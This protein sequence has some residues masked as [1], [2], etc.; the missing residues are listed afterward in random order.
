MGD[1]SFG[2]RL[3]VAGPLASREAIERVTRASGALGYSTLW[4]HDFIIWTRFLDRAHVS[5]GSVEAVDEAGLP[6]IFH[7]SLTNLAFLA[8]LT[9]GSDIK[10]GVAVLCLPYRNPIIAARQVANIDVLSGGRL[11]LGVGVGAPKDRNNR[12][13]EVLG[14]PRKG[15]YGR[16]REYVRA[17]QSI[18]MDDVSSF[19][20]EHISFPPEE[21]YPKPLQRPHPPIWLGGSGPTTLGMIAE[22]GSGWLPGLMAPS[23]FPEKLEHIYTAAEE[24]GRVEFDLTVATEITTCIGETRDEALEIGKGTIESMTEGFPISLEQAYACALFGSPEEIREQV[25]AYE[26]VGVT[27][28]E[29]KFIYHKVDQL[30]EEMELFSNEV[31]AQAGT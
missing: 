21:F 23:D 6:P 28:F 30:L 12:D 10:L 8:G 24:I 27:H 18:W 29:L 2:V 5:C 31:I 19:D 7:E 15:R 26:A 4:V 3:P 1:L 25:A 16:T 20:G 9:S 22:F 17:M 14:I 13:F 11:V